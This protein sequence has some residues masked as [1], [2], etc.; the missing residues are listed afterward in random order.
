[1]K[2]KI[3]ALII[4]VGC[5]IFTN[6]NQDSKYNELIIGKFYSVEY[7]EDIEWDDEIPISMTWEGY[8]EFF[9]NKTSVEDGTV[10]FSIYNE[11]GYNIIIEYQ[12]G[13]DTSKWEI[14]DGKL[15]YDFGIP[16]FKLNFK[17]TNAKGYSEREVV[18]YFREFIENDFIDIMKQYLVEE[19]DKPSK[20][21]ELNKN[22]LVT[23]DSDGEQ[24]IQKRIN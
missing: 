1:M 10:K 21:I 23:E 14:K 9:P 16:D 6:C 17:S 24:T 19:G 11:T 12:Y 5:L 13:P 4:I 22:R 2:R 7:V 15:Y 3:L 8:E 20:I 18:K